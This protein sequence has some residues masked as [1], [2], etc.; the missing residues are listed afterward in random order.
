MVVA[1]FQLAM[2]PNGAFAL[3]PEPLF[4]AQSGFC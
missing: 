2:L 1:G 4:L 3:F